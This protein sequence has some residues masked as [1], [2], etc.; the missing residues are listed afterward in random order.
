MITTHKNLLLEFDSI[1]DDDEEILWTGKPKFI[2]Y[3]IT[4]LGLGIGAIVFLIFYYIL[5]KHTR[6]DN[7]SIVAIVF[8]ITTLQFI[9]FLWRFFAKIFSYGNTSYAFSN[10]RIMVRTG[11]LSTG[12]KIID[13]R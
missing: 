13:L 1:K 11:F 2:P 6:S 7:G 5:T 4:S 12:F 3:A 10:K 8:W 9:A